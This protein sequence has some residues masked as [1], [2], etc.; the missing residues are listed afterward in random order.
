MVD[1]WGRG[2]CKKRCS[3]DGVCGN[4]GTLT[5]FVGTM[6]DLYVRGRYS[7]IGGRTD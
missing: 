4:D 3:I 5:G 7:V 2:Q 6:G 1:Q